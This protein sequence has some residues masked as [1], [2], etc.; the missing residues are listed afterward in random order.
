MADEAHLAV[1][2]GHLASAFHTVLQADGA[3]RH[4][5]FNLHAHPTAHVPNLENKNKTNN[6]VTKTLF[7]FN[8]LVLQY[9]TQQI[10]S[11]ELN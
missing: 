3:A 7:Y 11:T 9:L 10:Y 4:K 1:T 2:P 8:T 5:V 6:K